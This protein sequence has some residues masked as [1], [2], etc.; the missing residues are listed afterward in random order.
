MGLVSISV[1]LPPIALESDL[2]VMEAV[3]M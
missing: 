3:S 2:M 1:G